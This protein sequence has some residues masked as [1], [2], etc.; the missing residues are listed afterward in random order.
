M[1][2]SIKQLLE[3][4]NQELRKS[5]IESSQIDSLVI[6]ANDLNLSKEEVIFNPDKILNLGQIQKVKKSIERRSKREPL[7]HIIGKRGFYQDEF[8]V[9]RN[10]LD[11]RP[12]SESVIAA[13]LEQF[14][15]QNLP[16]KIAELGVGSGCLILTILKI[17]SN[18]SGIGV[19]LSDSA[20]EIANLNAQNLKIQDRIKLIKSNWFKDFPLRKFDLIISNP[21]YIKTREIDNLQEEVKFFEPKIAL[22]GGVDGLECYRVIAKGIVSFLEK[23][24]YV[25]LE[26]GQNQES[27][28]IEIFTENGLKFSHY[29]RDLA[30]I[31][32]CL[33]F[34]N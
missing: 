31:I 16:L 15:N 10:V 20:L 19:D 3:F 11:P 21:P 14:P 24:G 27:E 13:I 2:L 26:I 5:G 17:F 23:N 32:R 1:N 6:L 34:R 7:S 9:D 28:V 8:V 22:D 12:D 4:A 33:V 29:K 18:A 30:G 25:F